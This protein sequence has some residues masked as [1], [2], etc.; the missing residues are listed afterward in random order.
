MDNVQL[1]APVSGNGAAK[2]FEF[3]FDDDL[4]WGDYKKIAGDATPFAERIALIE[5]H[6]RVVNGDI[7]RAPTGAVIRALRAMIEQAANPNA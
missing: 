7:N 2:Q 4:E 3:V 5:T 6:V 1:S